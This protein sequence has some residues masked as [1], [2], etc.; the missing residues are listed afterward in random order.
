MA[1]AHKSVISF[2]LVAIPVGMYTAIQDNDIHFN[3]LHKEDNTRIKYKKQC[4]HCGKEIS[5]D[6]IIKGFEYDKDHYVVVTDDE[7]EKIKTEKG[8]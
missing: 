2:G 4:P 8:A 1:V 6:D 3:Q 7:I 5:A